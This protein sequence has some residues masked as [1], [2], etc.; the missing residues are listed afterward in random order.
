M[1]AADAAPGALDHVEI[2]VA[3]L[4]RTAAFWGWLLGELGWEP[5]QAWDSGRSWRLGTTYVVFVQAAARHLDPPY[6]RCRVGLNHLAFRAG[7]RAQVDAIAA[8]LERRGAT[9]LYRDRHPHAG[10][11]GHYALFFEDPDRIKVEIVAP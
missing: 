7:S 11:P 1:A 6:H 3:D 10:G 5:Y 8:A 9:I 2:Y 4:A